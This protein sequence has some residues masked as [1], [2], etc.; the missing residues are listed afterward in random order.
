MA[1]ISLIADTPSLTRLDRFSAPRQPHRVNRQQ[2]AARRGRQGPRGPGQ[3]RDAEWAVRDLFVALRPLGRGK[4]RG[5]CLVAQ[6]HAGILP[7]RH[8]G[9]GAGQDVGTLGQVLT[10]EAVGG[11]V[12][13]PIPCAPGARRGPG[14]DKAG[15][16]GP[17][18]RP[19]ASEVLAAPA[20]MVGT[21]QRAEG[22]G[23]AWRLAPT[24]AAVW[25]AT[26]ARRVNLVARV[27]RLTSTPLWPPDLSSQAGDARGGRPS[28]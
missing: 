5:R 3:E 12:A 18:H 14:Q 27:P 21:A 16:A 7:S 13:P 28:G 1:W 10:H 24:V 2:S 11:R 8:R 25:R 26:R 22:L 4:G 23:R 17:G 9:I 15:S 20:V 6:S 19:V